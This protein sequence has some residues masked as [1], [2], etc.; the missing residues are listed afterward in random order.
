M[1]RPLIKHSIDELERIFA[2]AS[3]EDNK[4][5][6]NLLVYELKYRKTSRARELKQSIEEVFKNSFQTNHH[7][8]P[9]QPEMN[10][11]LEMNFS[12]SSGV[13]GDIASNR[14]SNSDLKLKP[15]QEQ[16]EAIDAFLKGGTLKINAYA[17]TGK[18]S[19]LELLAH[20]TKKKGQYIAF[21][22]AIVKDAIDK[23]PNTV[24]CSTVHGLAYRATPSSYRNNN[25]KMT[26]KVNAH[27]L[28]EL[29]GL[30]KDLLVD[31]K[32]IL[33]PLAQGSIILKT[34]LQFTQSTDF[35]LKPKHVPPHG[36]LLAAP[37]SAMQ[38]VEEFAL[39]YARQVWARMQDSNDLMPLGHDGY[40]KMWALS[41]P[42]ILADFILLD[43]AQDTNPVVL[44]LLMNQ[45]A[46]M[47]YVGDKHQQIYEWRGA[48]NAMEKIITDNTTFLTKSFRFGN[49]IAEAA[50]KVISFL[51]RTSKPIEG[52]PRIKS[53]LGP[54]SP[55]T[56][57]ARTNASTITAV[58]EALNL[59]KK[60]HLVG[61]NGE[62]MEML[63]GVQDL[64]NNQPSTVADFFG[65]ENWDE[66]V[67]F[68]KNGEGEHLQT[69]VNLVESR[70]EKQ[71]MWALNRTV[72]EEKSDIII[73]TAHK[74]KGREWSKVRL[75]DDFLKS[76]P[77]QQNN[78]KQLEK[79]NYYDPAELRLFYVALTRAREELEVSSNVMPLLSLQASRLSN[80]NSQSRVL[81]FN[82]N[83]S[84][85]SL[86]RTEVDTPST[87]I[88]LDTKASN[89][90]F[91][92]D[93]NSHH[94]PITERKVPLNRQQEPAATQSTLQQPIIIE[95]KKPQ[96]KRSF[97]DWIFGK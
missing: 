12:Q 75:M 58:I 16:E 55:C 5:T 95:E 9:I 15:T 87:N 85:E 8:I 23:F 82:S 47:I 71:L 45:S 83:S 38:V 34:I 22:R 63:R 79:S 17:G 30:N 93:Q 27:K 89:T 97:L 1:T 77:R 4:K 64:K 67:E 11:E 40:L 6:L 39:R 68:S 44:E 7:N 84:L 53:R 52:N 18:T 62:I 2:K 50:N 57:L 94:L 74:A 78:S 42:I 72:D 65:F 43:E 88:V 90:P 31:E 13:R 3:F 80:N 19:T 14:R 28:A 73:S 86:S 37:K 26:G 25:L 21:N 33:K 76:S 96:K 48:V 70:G 35:E 36:A 66:V 29:L 46:Q 10:N 61:G 91:A 51:D 59:D 92:K 69:F 20:A 54:T 24:N 49:E 81:Q 41:D 56:I 60:P 32:I